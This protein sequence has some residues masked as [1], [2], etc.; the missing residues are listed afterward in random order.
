MRKEQDL[1][2][3]DFTIKEEDSNDGVKLFPL[4]HGD[5]TNKKAM[6]V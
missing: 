4:C 6:V 3:A 1:L 5:L 2:N